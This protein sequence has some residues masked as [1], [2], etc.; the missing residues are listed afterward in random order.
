MSKN[1][2]GESYFIGSSQQKEYLSKEA[3][4]CPRRMK[5]MQKN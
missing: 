2:G 1:R 3:V 5:D 4:R